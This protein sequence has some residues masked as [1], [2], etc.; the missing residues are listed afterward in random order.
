MFDLLLYT[1]LTIFFVGLIYR[2]S[3]WFTRKIGVSPHNYSS[4]Q[5]A[6]A[7]VKGFF[8]TLLSAKILTLAKAFLLD[9]LLQRRI[10]KEDFLRW[11]MHILIFVG[12][13]S[14]L[15][16]HALGRIIT[17]SLFPEYES[18]LNPFFFLRSLF[19][20][21]VF[22][23]VGIAIYRRFIVKV[24]RLRTSGADR[25]AIGILAA[26]LL[27]GVL[28]EGAKITSHSE[29]RSMAEDYAGLSGPWGENEE[30]Q[31][32][33]SYWVQY[34]G[35]VSPH[36][37]APFPEEVLAQGRDVHEMNCAACHDSPQW[38][39]TGYGAAK[40]MTPFALALDR[41]GGVTFLWWSHI[42]FSLFGLAYL[43]FSKMW[44]IFA[45]PVSLLTNAVMDPESAYPAN[46]M[47][48]QVM[49]LDACTHCGT[50]SL[51]CSALMAFEALGN[52]YILPGEKMGVLKRMAAGT[53]LDPKERRAILEGVYICTNCDRCT[54]SC[55]SGI[56]LR[57]LWYNVREELIQKDRPGPIVL[58]QLSFARGLRRERIY[59][60]T[61]PKPLEGEREALKSH[62]NGAMK[63]SGPISLGNGKEGKI[64]A[65]RA[66]TYSVC[67]G[68]QNCTTVCPV[69]ESY[70]DP[71]EALGLLP[72]QIMW[73]L[74]SGLAESASSSAMV[75][76]CVTCYQCQEHCPQKVSVAD[77]LYELRNRAFKTS[78]G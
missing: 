31:A 70:E 18:T 75:W 16:M 13:M 52:E 44:H 72:H 10:L 69:V 1:S 64:E 42:L 43:P 54:V 30:L 28:L 73:C 41:A 68:C 23:G 4:R 24:P 19:G 14:L 40:L 34:F 11:C 67:F 51:R 32:L 29:F 61:Y 3:T 74:G 50:C 49:E 76:N 71:E 63:G 6:T 8:G 26:V 25:Y 39:F 37:G 22:L 5:R 46:I 57:D 60:T 59:E 17:L 65:I 15:L 77:L 55:P 62:F 33:E 47:T 56:N 58:S 36:A 21:M 2:V 45:S 12:F 78:K 20:A 38:A 48:R 35:V 66:N 9:V 7:A 27:S 53:A